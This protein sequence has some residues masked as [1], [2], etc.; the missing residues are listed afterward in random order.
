MYMNHL[1]IEPYLQGYLMSQSSIDKLSAQDLVGT[2]HAGVDLALEQNVV[3]INERAER[4]DY[5]SFPHAR[6]DNY[7]LRR[8]EGL[9]QKY[10]AAKTMSYSR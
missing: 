2:L 10:Q 6:R 3:V 4:L 8:L 7:F 5:F 9:H 1:W